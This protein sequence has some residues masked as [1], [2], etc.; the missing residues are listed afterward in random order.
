MAIGLAFY[1]LIFPANFFF[2]WLEWQHLFVIGEKLKGGIG[3][4]SVV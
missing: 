3:K 2:P 1:D 4:A